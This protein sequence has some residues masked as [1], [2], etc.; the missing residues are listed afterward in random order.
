MS[1]SFGKLFLRNSTLSIVGT[2]LMLAVHFLSLKLLAKEMPVADFGIFTILLVVANGFEVVG[3]MGLSLTLVKSLAS[4]EDSRT[5]TVA[6]LIILSRAVAFLGLAILVAALGKPVLAYFFNPEVSQLA[7]FL[8]PLFI[9]GSCRN[10]LFAIQQGR[11]RFVSHATVKVISAILRLAAIVSLVCFAQLG[12]R[13]LLWVEVFV[14]A[15]TILL[16]MPGSALRQM[17]LSAKKLDRGI[18]GEVFSFSAPLYGADIFQYLYSR[19]TVLI[20]GALMLPGSVAI[21]GIAGKLPESC[22]RIL[23]SLLV[24]YFPSVA[25]LISSGRREEG[26]R[27]MN[28]VLLLVAVL[29]S[30]ATLVSFVLQEQIVLLLFSAQYLEAAPI[31][32]LLMCGFAFAGMT[33]LMNSTAVA[34]GFSS[35]PI[36]VSTI[37]SFVNVVCGLGLI[38]VWGISGA[39]WTQ[40]I[41]NFVAVGTSWFYLRRS[42]VAVDVRGMMV[43]FAISLGLVGMS[44][45]G[46]LNQALACF[47]ALVVYFALCWCLLPLVRQVCEQSVSYVLRVWFRFVP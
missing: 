11:K 31:L 38:P 37:S 8:P 34:S 41:A 16:L 22:G 42:G 43:P 36:R 35:V 25:E 13:E 32:P 10:T 2:V 30:A 29:L 47:L 45:L 39:A 4:G 12:V 46:S 28:V 17:I 1:T 5:L 9:L 21:Y 14:C 44:G 3:A 33:Q 19:L 15:I 6:G 7:W 18:V 23:Q 26:T 40:I 27:L 24:V 20:L